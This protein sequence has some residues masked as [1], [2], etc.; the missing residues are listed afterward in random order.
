[1]KLGRKSAHAKLGGTGV[2]FIKERSFRYRHDPLYTRKF[3]A[4]SP[5]FAEFARKNGR[6]L[7]NAVKLIRK[8]LAELEEGR[9][10]ADRKA[11]IYIQK[12]A[13]GFYKGRSWFPPLAV[14]IGG[15]ELFVKWFAG[16][17]E[18]MAK[19]MQSVDNYL[20][21]KNYTIGGFKV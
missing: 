3:V 17:V 18:H 8:N 19:T 15:K 9:K 16:D 14:R 1:M 5:E 13:T 7:M 20:K 4:Y 12:A 11:G 2:G 6:A 21:G 10:V